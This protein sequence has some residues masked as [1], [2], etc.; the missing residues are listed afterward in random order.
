MHQNGEL[1]F[2]LL[3]EKHFVRMATGFVGGVSGN[4]EREREIKAAMRRRRLDN[5]L[6]TIWPLPLF[7]TTCNATRR[8]E[9]E[10]LPS[11]QSVLRRRLQNH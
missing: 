5:R 11:L 6:A 3:N 4:T 10:R 7:T 2:N 9:K 1:P 8:L